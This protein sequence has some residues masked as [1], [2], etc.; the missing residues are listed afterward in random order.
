[1]LALGTILPDA[2]SLAKADRHADKQQRR[3][4]SLADT[5]LAAYD[6]IEVEGE[7]RY[8]DGPHRYAIACRDG[9]IRWFRVAA[10]G[11]Y[12]E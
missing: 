1:M 10:L 12:A 8:Y 3:R 6:K 4:S 2:V 7:D 11:D 5:V 9:K